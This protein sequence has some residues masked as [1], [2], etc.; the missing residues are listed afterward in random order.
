MTAPAPQTPQERNAQRLA[1]LEAANANPSPQRAAILK[2]I[3]GK[4]HDP[5]PLPP[6]AEGVKP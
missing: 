2:A 3:D 6:T 1:A 5:L 4:P